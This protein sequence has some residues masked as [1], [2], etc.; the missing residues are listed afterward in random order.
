MKEGISTQ[1]GGSRLEPSDEPVLPRG[2]FVE[3]IVSVHAPGS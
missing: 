2:D 3:C 1:T